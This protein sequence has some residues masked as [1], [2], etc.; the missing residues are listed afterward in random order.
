[1]GIGCRPMIEGEQEAVANLL[2]KLPRDLGFDTVPKLTGQSLREHADL[3]NV[4]VATDSGLLLGAATWMLTFSSNR[5]CKGVY[6]CDLYVME[7]KRGSGIGE[8]LL[9]AVAKA[10]QKRG[11]QFMKL[12]SSRANPRPSKF[13]R[14]HKFHVS[15]DD[16][17]MFLEGD[18]MMMF[19]EGQSK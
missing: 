7:H 10:A 6:I 13:Y 11:A 18:E 19:L 4:M 3:V 12:E 9:R 2:R 14:K 15:E 17:V 1:M 16:A 5:G 8:K